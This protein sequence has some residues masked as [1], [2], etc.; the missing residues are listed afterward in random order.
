MEAMGVEKVQKVQELQTPS[1]ASDLRAEPSGGSE[2]FASAPPPAD[3]AS[4][5]R[6]QQLAVQEAACGKHA[7]TIRLHADMP[8]SM[9][10]KQIAGFLQDPAIKALVLSISQEQQEQGEAA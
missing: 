4:L 10:G 6:W 3:V 7:A 9:S 1:P 2:P 5:T 8:Q